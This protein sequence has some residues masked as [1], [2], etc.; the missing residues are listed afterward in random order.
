MHPAFESIDHRPWPLPNEAWC[1]QQ[2]W[3]D[4]AFLHY[5][6]S[7]QEIRNLLPPDVTLQEFDGSAW[8]GV[9]PFWM[10]GFM[11]RPPLDIPLLS[12]F[13]EIN[14]RTYVEVDG[15][16]G[17]W[18]FSLDADNWPIVLVG[19]GLYNLPY[20]KAAITLEERKGW[21]ECAS[22]RHQGQVGFKGRYRPVGDT[23]IAESGSF[24]AWATERYCLYSQSRK[25]DV[26]RVE[27]HHAPWPLQKAEAEI[28]ACDL[29]SAAG[30]SPI[31]STMVC[32]Y[33]AG[34]QVVSYPKVNTAESIELTPVVA[35][36]P[37]VG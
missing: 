10:D 7:S 35:E 11:R 8:V 24:E 29:F 36:T 25:G 13:P 15:K 21:F 16:P 3:L 30:I 37:S 17:V 34:V 9:V 20:Y 26:Q 32:H 14:L 4:L 6:V 1:W 23:F 31:D 12:S 2:S 22:T 28:E 18:F 19:R 5:R 27:V 33:S